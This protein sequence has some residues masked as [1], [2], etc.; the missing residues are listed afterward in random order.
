M[1]IPRIGDKNIGRFAV[2]RLAARLREG[3]WLILPVL[4]IFVLGFAATTL[5]GRFADNEMRKALISRAGTAAA[6]PDEDD[7]AGLRGDISDQTSAGYKKVQRWLSS[8]LDVNEDAHYVYLFGERNGKIVFLADSGNRR[9]SEKPTAPGTVYTSASR[10][11]ILSFKN[12]KPFIEGPAPDEWG[13]WYSGL[14]P[15]KSSTDG[16]VR[17]VL[18]FDIDAKHWQR[19]CL[20][21]QL[22]PALLTIAVGILLI[23]T[24]YTL[25]HTRKW[26]S[27][28]ATSEEKHRG[29]F[30]RAQE[31]IFE[32]DGDGNLTSMNPYGEALLGYT[33]EEMKTLD[34]GL[35]LVNGVRSRLKETGILIPVSSGYSRHEVDLVCKDGRV[36]TV[37]ACTYQMLSDGKV[38]SVEGFAHDITHLKMMGNELRQTAIAAQ[39]ASK[40]KG[41]FLANMSHEIRTPLNG[42]IGMSN[43]LLD[44][45]LD[46][47]QQRYARTISYSADL[48]LGLINDILDFSK[49]ESGKMELESHPFQLHDM[50]EGLVET[51]AHRAESKG[52][53]LINFIGEEVPTMVVGDQARVRQVLTNLI[54]NAIK[55]TDH[56][57]VTVRCDTK[58]VTDSQATLRFSVSD[59]GIGM[60]AEAKHRLFN[61]FTQLDGS[62]TRKYG[63][64][65]LGL[66]ISK[67]LVNMMGGEID[68]ESQMGSGSTFWFEIPFES[69]QPT[70]INSFEHTRQLKV[71]VLDDNE[72]NRA[73]LSEQLAHWGIDSEKAANAKDGLELMREAAD[74]SRRFDIALVD[75]QMPD[76]DGLGF[77][78]MV[79]TT[80]DLADTPLILLGSID[81]ALDSPHM[82]KLSFSACLIKPIRQSQL[83]DALV[84][85]A[86]GQS[87]PGK[88]FTGA[89]EL[90]SVATSGS[91]CRTPILVVE[92]NEVNRMVVGEILTKAGYRY[93][94]VCNGREAVD[95]VVDHRYC[96][97]LM[98]CQMPEMDGFEATRYIRRTEELSGS[99]SHTP[100]VALTAN[101]MNED[102]ERC[103][104]AG[105]DDYLCKPI[106]PQSLLKMIDK[107][108][109]SEETGC[110]GAEVTETTAD[111]IPND[112]NTA[113]LEPL[114]Y[115]QLASRCGNDLQVMDAVIGVFKTTTPQT[116][117][118]IGIA[119]DVHDAAQL[120]ALAHRLKGSSATMSAGR[121]AAHAEILEKLGHE[122]R[123]EEVG[124]R[125]EQIKQEFAAFCS[126]TELHPID[127]GIPP[128]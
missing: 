95:A 47:R 7:V 103:I 20:L 128:V 97:I 124:E 1:G 121:I 21:Y 66:A 73:V 13:V 69:S 51:F 109:A 75:L 80:S 71:L 91:R 57:E 27:R 35:L 111:F 78:E 110:P 11:L 127:Q 15:I 3:F 23:A 42:V 19:M 84:R 68:V 90:D 18:G 74:T 34:H 29:L 98:D 52:I 6:I 2:L 65:G 44:T 39:E 10:E 56:G 100:I 50:V 43:L 8:I 105:M 116:I 81:T 4:L 85:A 122:A 96:L 16:H 58:S 125:F 123:W 26:N 88:A 9:T 38:I 106:M 83:F 12:G 28:L 99:E 37:D 5:S 31:M 101:A 45:Q 53:E 33:T 48:L 89:S 108:I 59:T 107:W 87:D 25:Q 113:S 55:F 22:V 120:Q 46:E 93:D 24:L 54:G 76:V 82:R 92:D 102:R 64:T 32:L 41:D 79:R 86:D 117:A 94:A 60:P 49:I 30:D 63:G 14:V 118:E 62:T 114:N 36:V 17:A 72:V 115:E 77:A 40:A 61:S 104:D 112:K 126:Y 70:Q 119:I 67:R